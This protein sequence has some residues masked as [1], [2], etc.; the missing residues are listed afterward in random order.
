MS[1]AQ[2]SSN[3]DPLDATALSD[4]GLNSVSFF[5]LSLRAHNLLCIRAKAL[6]NPHARCEDM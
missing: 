2:S 1:V 3:I 5:C 6:T 4:T